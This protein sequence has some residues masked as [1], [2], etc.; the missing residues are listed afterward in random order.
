MQNQVTGRKAELVTAGSSD[1][2]STA[3]QGEQPETKAGTLMGIQ[4]CCFLPFSVPLS[5]VISRSFYQV[6]FPNQVRNR[7][8]CERNDFGFRVLLSTFVLPRFLQPFLLPFLSVS[9]CV[10]SISPR[11]TGAAAPSQSIHIQSPGGIFASVSKLSFASLAQTKAGGCCLIPVVPLAEESSR[12]WVSTAPFP[13]L[14]H[15]LMAG[16]APE[17]R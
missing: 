9:C 2:E 15:S 7:V 10:V 8:G 17:H 16:E 6:S 11:E 3:R 14:S 12:N 13:A 5:G 1:S 4:C